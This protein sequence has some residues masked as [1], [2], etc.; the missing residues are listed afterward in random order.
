MPEKGP[1]IDISSIAG[2]AVPPS[3]VAALAMAL[4]LVE[5]LGSPSDP[6]NKLSE[7]IRRWGSRSR[8]RGS[9]GGALVGR[10]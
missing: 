5:K 1:P 8:R 10:R 4:L 9:M 6:P 3:L 2:V 7:P